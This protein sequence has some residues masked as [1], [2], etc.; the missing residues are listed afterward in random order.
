M[1]DPVPVPEPECITVPVPILLRRKVAVPAV[2]IPHHWLVH[3]VA[4]KQPC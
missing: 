3:K 4:D 1:L 2:P